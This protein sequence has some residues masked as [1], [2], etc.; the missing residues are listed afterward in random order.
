M[1]HYFLTIARE[2]SITKAAKVLNMTQPPLS[3]QIKELEEELG[4]QLLIRGSKK[5]AL[6][7][8]GRLLKKRAEEMIN[9]MDKT[10]SELTSSNNHI[11]G[12]IL[13]GAGETEGL[14]YLAQVA[15][16]LQTRYPQIF[17]KLYSGDAT[18]VTEKLDSGLLDFGLLIGQVDINK[19][20]YLKLPTSD[21]WGVIMKEDSELAK[22]DSIRAEYLI[23]KP[24]ILSHQAIENNEL[25]S[26]LQTSLSSL[27]IVAT[28]ELAYNASIFV[29]N[30]FGYMLALDNII[31]TTPGSGLIFKPLTP[32]IEVGMCIVWKKHQVFGTAAKTFL[33]ELRKQL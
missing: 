32:T 8:E 22:Y 31:N 33:S 15:K 7:E 11:S 20:D 18:L 28:Y 24:L 6:T 19:Y 4:T 23:D 1:L 12:E 27:N 17:Y 21:R 3:R 2:E 25:A 14:S 9:L 13:I 26:W 10:V 5:I 30:G 29:K 16:Q